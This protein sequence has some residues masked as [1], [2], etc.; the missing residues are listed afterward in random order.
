MYFFYC[1][2]VRQ[3]TIEEATVT[4]FLHDL[5]AIVPGELAE[6]VACVNDRIFQDLRIPQYKDGVCNTNYDCRIS[7]WSKIF[8]DSLTSPVLIGNEKLKILLEGKKRK[9]VTKPK[10]EVDLLSLKR[11]K[12]VKM[13]IF[14]SL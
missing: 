13:T 3:L 14:Y 11:V 6:P 2:R 7:R 1:F 5:Y 9:K 8:L 12:F 10:E 4:V